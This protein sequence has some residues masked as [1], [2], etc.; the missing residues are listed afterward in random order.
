MSIRSA[1]AE[2][3]GARHRAE[4]MSRVR[5]QKAQVVRLDEVVEEVETSN[6]ENGQ[7]ITAQVWDELAQLADRLPVP[8]PPALWRARTGSRLHSALLDWQDA[9]LDYVA[10]QRLRF[11][12]RHD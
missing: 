7:H 11:V 12:D 10:P 9:V 1:N 8:A 4:L 3:E 2:L 5:E 6:L